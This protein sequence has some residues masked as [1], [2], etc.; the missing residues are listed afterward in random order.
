MHW[1]DVRRLRGR[2]GR[3]LGRPCL[4]LA[5][6]GGGSH[7]A[8]TWGVLDRLLETNCRIVGVSGAS[9]GALNAAAL[10]AGLVT[11][12]RDGARTSLEALWRGVA[13]QARLGP[14]QST[15][16][17]GLLHGWNRD[18]SPGFIMLKTVSR[19]ASPYQVNPLGFNPLTSILEAAIDFDALGHRRAPRLQ[20]ALTRVR[21]GRLVIHRN[22]EVG[23]RSLLGST[24]L[25]L[26]FQA[27]EID[28]EHYWDGGYTGNPPLFPLVLETAASD[29]LLVQLTPLS[30][31]TVPSQAAD[32]IDRANEMAF[33][34]C[35]HRE[36]QVLADLRRGGR[37]SGIRGLRLHRLAAEADTA[38]L[39]GNSRINADWAFLQHLRDRGRER[40]DAWLSGGYAVID[41]PLL[42]NS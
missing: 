6:Q 20:V 1:M 33:Q 30:R 21:D 36:L 9:A 28:G 2:L 35:L 26:L 8:F 11:G 31:S 23:V 10:V 38:G 22:G 13:E 5:L 42:E 15:P 40:A 18:Y 32:I 41:D 25:P 12:G 29:L 24:C 4:A 39:G 7:G 27:I 37:L 3:V 19:V 34:S 14:L 16:L 17:D